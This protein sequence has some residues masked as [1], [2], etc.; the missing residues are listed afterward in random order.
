[1][2]AQPRPLG[3][4]GDSFEAPFNMPALFQVY[5]SGT[6][7][8]RTSVGGTDWERSAVPA[9]CLGLAAGMGMRALWP[10]SLVWSHGF[11]AYMGTS[12]CVMCQQSCKVASLGVL[13]TQTAQQVCGAL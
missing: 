6:D 12:L 2:G 13:E 4:Q 10:S 3:L 7:R 8:P 11:P 5:V 1:M 9:C